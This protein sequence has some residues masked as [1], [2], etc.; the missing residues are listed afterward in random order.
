MSEGGDD[1]R[2]QETGRQLLGNQL[3]E[4]KGQLPGGFDTMV[5]GG[6]A[7]GPAG[8]PATEGPLGQ[9]LSV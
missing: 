5:A 6:T 3:E 7:P 8:D 4:S 1:K 9:C 2:V